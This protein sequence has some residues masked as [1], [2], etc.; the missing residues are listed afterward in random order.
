[1]AHIKLSHIKVGKKVIIKS[2]ESDEL[3]LKL[4][5]MGCLPGET[6]TVEPIAPL[7]DPISITVAGYRLSLRLD[8]ADHIFVEEI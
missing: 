7:R 1:M 5:E 2:F 6:I 3:F 4:M 8:E